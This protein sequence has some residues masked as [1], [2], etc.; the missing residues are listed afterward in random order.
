MEK[1]MNKSLE[2]IQAE[3]N[4]VKAKLG[5]CDE[6]QAKAAGEQKK[7]LGAFRIK[8]EAR[9]DRLATALDILSGR[10]YV[11]YDIDGEL[12]VVRPSENTA[13]LIKAIEEYGGR[14]TQLPIAKVEVL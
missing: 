6:L 9:R 14:V 10:D 3:L 13:K 7:R 11:I 8:L 5:K 2:A 12:A 1:N 4:E